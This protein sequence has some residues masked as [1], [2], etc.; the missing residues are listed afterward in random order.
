MCITAEVPRKCLFT[1]TYTV[2]NQGKQGSC[3]YGNSCVTGRQTLIP[4]LTITAQVRFR[5]S[6]K[7]QNACRVWVGLGYDSLELGQVQTARYVPDHTLSSILGQ[8]TEKMKNKYRGALCMSTALHS[9]FT[10]L[11]NK[12][13]YIKML[14]VDFTSA[15]STIAPMMLIGNLTLGLSTTLVAIGY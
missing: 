1:V 10:H 15:F 11:E 14:F 3:N 8:G 9:A 13:S 7:K 2:C 6:K 5:C 4:Q 12:I